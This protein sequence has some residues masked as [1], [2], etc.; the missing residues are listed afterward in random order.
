MNR[1]TGLKLLYYLNYTQIISIINWLIFFYM[2]FMFWDIKQVR[3]YYF[4]KAVNFAFGYCPLSSIL[5]NS[6]I[7]PI[8]FEDVFM[9]QS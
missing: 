8:V 9:N 6:H 2:D 7:F 1:L 3:N 5:I 4:G